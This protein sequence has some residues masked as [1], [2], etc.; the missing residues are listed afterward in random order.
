MAGGV[1]DPDGSGKPDSPSRP[2]TS[3]GSGLATG[4][5]ARRWEL[6]GGAA[7]RVGVDLRHAGALMRGFYDMQLDGVVRD[8]DPTQRLP[9]ARLYGAADGR[10]LQLYGVNASLDARTPAGPR[11]GP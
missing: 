9:L 4:P 10:W 3:R 2:G 5:T 6:R 1:T 11:R 7:Q 8:P